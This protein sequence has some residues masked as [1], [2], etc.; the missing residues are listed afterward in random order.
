MV[1]RERWRYLLY[2]GMEARRRKLDNR[3]ARSV[4][5]KQC[6]GNDNHDCSRDNHDSGINHDYNGGRKGYYDPFRNYDKLFFNDD[7]DSGS[8]TACCS[9]N[10]NND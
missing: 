7:N 5:P 9:S 1:L 10:A 2:A 4:H 3:A 6:C 8:T